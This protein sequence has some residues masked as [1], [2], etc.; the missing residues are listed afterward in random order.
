MEVYYVWDAV[1]RV[2]H[3]INFAAIGTLILTGLYI[4]TPFLRA[5]ADEP[6][7]ASTMATARNLHFLAAVIFACNG[8]FRVYWFFGGGTYRQ[9][10]R[11]DPWKLNYWKEV[12]WKLRDYLSLRYL[13]GERHTLEHNALA[14]FS[15]SV[16]FLLAALMALSGFSMAGRI[17]PG[18]WLD[19][20]F[21]WVIPLLGGEASVRMLHRLGMWGIICFMIHHIAFVFYFAVLHEKG[22]ISSMITGLKTRPPEWM[23][24]HKPWKS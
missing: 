5:A 9:W 22:I 7:D 20:W 24:K 23:L 11:F 16:T 12:G 19:V 6:F 18:G 4:G 14:S 2:T 15:Y 10:F 17:N 21:G 8:F 1:V 3:W 13:D